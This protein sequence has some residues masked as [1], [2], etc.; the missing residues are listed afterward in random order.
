MLFKR[1]DKQRK[2]K[3]KDAGKKM[4]FRKK[5]CKFCL[6]K[7]NRVDYKDTLKLKKYLTEKGKILPCHFTGN[8]AKHQR[9]VTEAVK[10]ARFIAL[11]PFVGE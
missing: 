5:S 10:K 8:C 3:T 2:K 11:L 7:I 6:E 4:F 1:D 9:A